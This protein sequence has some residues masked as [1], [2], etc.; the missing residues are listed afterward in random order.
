MGFLCEKIKRFANIG[1]NLESSVFFQCNMC[2]SSNNKLL[3]K[4]Q[5][6]EKKKNNYGFQKPDVKN[7]Y[8]L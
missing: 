7:Y 8:K 3:F 1:E 4:N 2:F 5:N 6:I